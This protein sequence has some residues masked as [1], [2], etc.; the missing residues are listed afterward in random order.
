MTAQADAIVLGEVI[1]VETV[2]GG[3]R[4]AA[5]RVIKSYKGVV[6]DRV[7]FYA[8]P[9]W[10]CDSSWAEAGEQVLLFLHRTKSSELFA[11]AEDGRGRMVVRNVGG[12]KF[13]EPILL[14]LPVDVRLA[15][16]LSHD[17]GWLLG[18]E[19]ASFDDVLN[20]VEHRRLPTP[21][22]GQKIS[23][24]LSASCED[25]GTS[26]HSGRGR[27]CLVWRDAA[28]LQCRF[29]DDDHSVANCWRRAPGEAPLPF[30]Q[31]S[32]AL[33]CERGVRGREPELRCTNHLSP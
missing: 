8:S 25:A 27:E 17:G 2:D 16:R 14:D 1:S 3:Q 12:V 4:V 15:K 28:E 9:E 31:P 23:Y 26:S 29:S 6:G 24:S 10:S 32:A 19:L 22:R 33:W 20:Y 18:D 21:L 11:L 13:L 7:R 5:A 30:L